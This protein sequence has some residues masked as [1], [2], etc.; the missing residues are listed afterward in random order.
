M[1]RQKDI[2]KPAK[3]AIIVIVLFHVVG[4]VGFAIPAFQPLFKQLVPYHLLLMLVVIVLSH[5]WLDGKFLFFVLLIA[6]LG[7]TAEWVG[8]HKHW[9]FGDYNY[10]KT[11]G[12]KLLDIPLLIGVNWFLLIYS[13]G[14]AMQHSR[15]RNPLVRIIIGAALLV[16]LDVLIEPV[17]IKFDYWSWETAT[18]PLKNYGCWFGVS[19]LLLSLFESFGF[20]KQN[21]AALV[22]LITQFLFFGLLNLIG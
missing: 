10:G 7:F 5:K 16:L 3:V 2:V 8:V 6:A 17:A 18:I 15:L 1:E 22:L 4:L 11:L 13:A 20:K 12:F 19:V 14:V 9:L 21:F